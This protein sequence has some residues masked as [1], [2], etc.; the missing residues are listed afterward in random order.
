MA[1]R[2]APAANECKFTIGHYSYYDLRRVM[3]S[4]WM[5]VDGDVNKN[6]ESLDGTGVQYDS[7]SE[8]MSTRS[9]LSKVSFAASQCNP[10]IVGI[11]IECGCE[12][13]GGSVKIDAIQ[14]FNS[15]S[16]KNPALFYNGTS[17]S[18][19]SCVYIGY[20]KPDEKW[21]VKNFT[22]NAAALHCT[23]KECVQGQISAI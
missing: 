13:G 18:D 20:S 10:C 15:W 1:I 7:S 21:G 2:S 11:S 9:A 16:N 23:T 12:A 19:P 8:L 3:K 17:A 14:I 22:I 5:T 4:E 6:S